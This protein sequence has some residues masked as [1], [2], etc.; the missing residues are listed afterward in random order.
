MLYLHALAAFYGMALLIGIAAGLRTMTPPA[1]LCWA[2]QIGWMGT[3][4][5][6][7]GFLRSKITLAIFTVLAIVELIA[8]QLPMT[9]S[10][11]APAPFAARITSGA[12]CG[13]AIA[14]LMEWWVQGAMIGAAGAVFG[15]LVGY[16]IR[17]RSAKAVGKDFP[18]ALLE[19]AVAI[20]GA[21][22]AVHILAW[23]ML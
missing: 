10:R 20:G 6:A 19:D 7:F 2:M 1:M 14:D 16:E 11:K 3:H 23:E 22:V 9:P 13:A 4:D 21:F 15:T 18:I 17:T 5:A 8:D 12:F